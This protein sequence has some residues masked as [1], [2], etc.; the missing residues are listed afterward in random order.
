MEVGL[1]VSTNWNS[2]IVRSR[3][4]LGLRD[5][6]EKWKREENEEEMK[7]MCHC[8]WFDQE[9]YSNNIWGVTIVVIRS[10]HGGM[11]LYR[12]FGLAKY[13]KS[14]LGLALFMIGFESIFKIQCIQ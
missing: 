3:S 5:K 14:T 1:N 9:G 8:F 6:D 4:G 11:G 7:G 12:Y 13:E 10:R 2:E